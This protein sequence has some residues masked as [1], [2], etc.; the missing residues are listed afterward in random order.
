MKIPHRILTLAATVFAA[1][2]ILTGEAPPLHAESGRI[3]ISLFKVRH[4]SL[5]KI[6]YAAHGSGNLF[7]DGKRYRLEIGGISPDS[8]KS[9][10]SDLSGDVEN[11]HNASDILGTYGPAEPG[12]SAVVESGRPV[13]LKNKTGA[14]LELR[15][16]NSGELTLD[17]SGLTLIS[18]GW[19]PDPKEQSSH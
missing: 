10:R 6:R 5:F 16:V 12:A 4:V 19:G 14:I 11:I 1:V 8:L 18:R 2:L 9:S 15:G 7:Y 13:R 3:H 17:L